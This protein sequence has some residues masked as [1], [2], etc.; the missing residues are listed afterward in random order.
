MTP[1]YVLHHPLYIEFT[2]GIY[3]CHEAD[4]IDN[5]NV[6]FSDS[7]E[8]VSIY[9]DVDKCSMDDDGTCTDDGPLLHSEKSLFSGFDIVLR[10]S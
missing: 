6:C 2:K 4:L 1:I 3:V 8:S 9:T 10:R 7:A 5:C